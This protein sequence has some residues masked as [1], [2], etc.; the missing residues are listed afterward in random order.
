MDPQ[1]PSS[2]LDIQ[3]V[4]KNPKQ[5][6]IPNLIPVSGKC[7]LPQWVPK[8]PI[9]TDQQE[10]QHEQP[11]QSILE[12]SSSSS[13]LSSEKSVIPTY[14]DIDLDP[15]VDTVCQDQEINSSAPSQP[16][17]VALILSIL[18]NSWLADAPDYVIPYLLPP[19][20]LQCKR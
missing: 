12:K 8:Q 5:Q 2:I 10:P 19:A 7:T 15:H 14:I 20:A 9:A 3:P 1:N 4:A 13:L 11:V 16:L 17:E 6:Q 18:N